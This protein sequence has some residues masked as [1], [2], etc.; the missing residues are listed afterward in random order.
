MA[1]ARKIARKPKRGPKRVVRRLKPRTTAHTAP[2]ETPAAE[3]L[4]R[5]RVYSK[6]TA[7]RMLDR[8]ANGETPTEVCRDGT[9]PTWMVLC[10]W[11]RQHDDFD[12]RFRIAWESCAEHMVGDIVIIADDARNDYVDRVTRKGVIR[13]FDREHFERSRLRVESRKWMAQKVLR[14]TYGER[15]EVDL[16]ASG[17]VNVRV[18]ERNALINA[19]VKLVTP[20]VDGVTKP[21]G[22]TEEARER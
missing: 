1:P 15:R 17:G 6:E 22:R 19:L 4:E 12:K 9:M 21:S 20:K 11:R 7:D 2:E 18:E 13:V 3:K 14:A 8:I 10:R 5:P 16:H